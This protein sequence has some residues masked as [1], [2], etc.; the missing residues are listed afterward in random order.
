MYFYMYLMLSATL[1]F[2]G[3]FAALAAFTTLAALA[4]ITATCTTE[5]RLRWFW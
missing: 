1:A 2:F 5:Q 3:V 4:V